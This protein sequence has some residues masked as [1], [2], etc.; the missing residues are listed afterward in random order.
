VTNL[1]LASLITIVSR[2]RLAGGD[3]SV[4]NKLKQMLSK[5]CDDGEFL[6]VL[7]ERIELVGKCSLELLTCD[8]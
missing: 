6:A 7:S 4:V 3:G 5:A 1:R 8:V 2:T